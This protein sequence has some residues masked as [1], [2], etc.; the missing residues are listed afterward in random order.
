MN[1]HA[2][3]AIFHLLVIAP[4]FFYIAVQ[5]AAV[6]NMIYMILAILAIV[7]FLYHGYKMVARWKSNSGYAWVN[8]IHFFAVAPL[9]FY[10]GYNNKDTPRAAYEILAMFA[11]AAFGY[12]LY[13]LIKSINMID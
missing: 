5:R 1:Q 12:H 8:A 10:I 13:S 11:F 4:F 9:L 6:P 2:I 3:L 7:I